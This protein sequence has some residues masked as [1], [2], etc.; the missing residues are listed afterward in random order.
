LVEKVKAECMQVATSGVPIGAGTSQSEGEFRR[1][2]SQ[3][4]NQVANVQN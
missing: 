2:I 1:D 4:K 3:L